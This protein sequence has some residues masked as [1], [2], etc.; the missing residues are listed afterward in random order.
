METTLIGIRVEEMPPNALAERHKPSFWYSAIYKTPQEPKLKSLLNRVDQDL[1]SALRENSEIL[2]HGS[3]RVAHG[4]EALET[5]GPR[6]SGQ[7]RIVGGGGHY[8]RLTFLG[9]PAPPLEGW[10]DFPLGEQE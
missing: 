8:V 10:D 1:T 2:D 5:L 3:I 6:I 4:I 7:R 9:V